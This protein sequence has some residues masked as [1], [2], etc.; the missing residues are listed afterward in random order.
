M[1]MGN[2]QKEARYLSSPVY[3]CPVYA[4]VKVNPDP[5]PP[6]PPGYVG[7]TWGGGA[8]VGLYQYIGSSLSPQYVGESQVLSLLAWRMWGIS[9]GFVVIQDRG[10]R[11]RK[12]FWVY[13]EKCYGS[14]GLGYTKTWVLRGVI[15]HGLSIWFRSIL[16][17]TFLGGTQSVHRYLWNPFYC[18]SNQ[19]AKTPFL[20]VADVTYDR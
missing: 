16:S 2:S 10:D 9:R 12:D 14:S 1:F 19:Y 7:L 11:S 3:H 6:S 4:S 20:N 8:Y 17:S 18:Y 13:F 15:C 5:P